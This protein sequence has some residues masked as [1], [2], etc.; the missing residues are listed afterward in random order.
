MG[1]AILTP[2]DNPEKVVKAS[3]CMMSDGQ[4]SVEEK[5]TS[6]NILFTPSSGVTVMYNNSKKINGIAYIDIFLR[7]SSTITS[8]TSMGYFTNIDLGGYKRFTTYASSTAN[9]T[10]DRFTNGYINVNQLFIGDGATGGMVDI[11]LC[12]AIPL[13]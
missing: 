8:L 6:G 3:N 4:T 10:I 7:V 12:I 13:P 2:I 5:I 9:G 11:G 1:K